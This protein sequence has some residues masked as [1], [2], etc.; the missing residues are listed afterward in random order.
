MR[1]AHLARRFF[2]S[3]VARMPSA[4]E[5]AWV[6]SLLLP[7]EFELWVR[8]ARYDRRHTLGAARRVER[9][10]GPE[11]E[12]IW[13]AAALLHDVGKVEARLGIPGRVA[14]TITM[15]VI[16]YARVVSWATAPGVSGRFGRYAAHGEI[17]AELVRASGGR[18]EVAVWAA[19]HHRKRSKDPGTVLG[20]PQ[21]VVFALRDS[22][23][24]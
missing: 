20:L 17:G 12:P 4:D 11:S 6:R 22:D 5:E 16:G 3:L 9:A 2:A 24:D 7:G 14:A 19:A 1:L 10:L 15:A 13:L 8:Q 21:A 23:R 18:D